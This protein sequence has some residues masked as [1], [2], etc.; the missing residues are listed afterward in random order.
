MGSVVGAP[1]R[2]WRRRGEKSPS[3]TGKSKPDFPP[4]QPVVYPLCWLKF[5]SST[6]R[7]VTLPTQE[8]RYF[9]AIYHLKCSA[10]NFVW[11][12]CQISAARDVKWSYSPHYEAYLIQYNKSCRYL[13]VLHA[14]LISSIKP[15]NPTVVNEKLIFSQ[16]PLLLQTP[17]IHHL[18]HCNASFLSVWTHV[19]S[20]PRPIFSRKFRSSGLC[21]VDCRFDLDRDINCPNRLSWFSQPLEINFGTVLQI[22]SLLHNFVFLA[23]SY[24]KRWALCLTLCVI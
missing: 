2:V 13:K 1:Q 23:I 16:L 7:V 10:S 20:I 9:F 15:V 11:S 19:T 6:H 22:V 14:P 17:E 24:S 5:P 18:V 8:L 4:L 21:P 12:S 3:H